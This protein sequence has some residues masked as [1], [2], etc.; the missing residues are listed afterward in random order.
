MILII[1]LYCLINVSLKTITMKRFFTLIILLIFAGSLMAQTPLQKQSKALRTK[2]MTAITAATH[3]SP[4]FETEL[5]PYVANDKGPDIVIGT[6]RY[7]LPTNATM[8]R[9]I[10]AFEDGSIG[11]TWTMGHND[12]N[13]AERGTGYNFNDGTGWAPVPTDRIESVRTGWPDYQPY[14]ENGEII[15]AHTGGTDGLIFSWRENKNEGEWNTFYLQ[16]PAGFQDLLWPRMI[17]SGDFND[18]IH[19]IAVVDAEYQ[20][21]DGALLYSRSFDGGQTWDPHNVILPGLAA[22]EI[23]G[24]GGDI[25]AWAAPRGETIAFCYG[26]FIADGIVL[27]SND[28]GDTWETMKYY[29]APVP[30]FNHQVPLPAHGGLD[31]HQAIVLDDQD[32]VHIAVGRMVLASDGPGATGTN[33]YPY[34]NGLLYWNETMPAMD[35]TALTDSILNVVNVNPMYLLAEVYDNGID[36]IVDVARY[37]ASLT[38][39]PQ[40]VFDESRKILYAFYSAIT[41]GFD[42]DEFNYRH[43]WYRFS[44]DYGVTWSEQED[45]TGDVFHLFSEC[46]WPSAASRVTDKVHVLFHSDNIPGNAARFEEHPYNDNQIVYLPVNQIVGLSE[47]APQLLSIDQIRPNPATSEVQIIVNVNKAVEGDVTLMNLM[48]QE[49]YSSNYLFGY[50]GPHNVRLDLTQV[51]SGIYFVRIKAGTTSSVKKLIVQ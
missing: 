10:H 4:S 19:V 16:G 18:V 33:Y 49:I 46:V 21:L 23:Y 51:E 37:Q 27:K 14:L 17:T 45:L 40:L 44:E 48:G 38:S 50:A 13:F 15:C 28:N 25:Y 1:Y 41:L 12:P 32:R 22:G 5:N 2:T 43:I 20:G 34:S 8:Q 9:R 7:D 31:A 42:N 47:Q 3:Y 29:E 36:D 6:T 26:D 39:M 30:A 11:A 35:S 24:V